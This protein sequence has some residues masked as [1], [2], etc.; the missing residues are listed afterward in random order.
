MIS[1]FLYVSHTVL[2][3]LGWLENAFLNNY[4]NDLLCLPLVLGAAIFFQRNIVLRQPAYALSKWQIGV[5][6]IYFSVM[7]E[8]VFPQFMPRYTADFFDVICYGLGGGL[9][10]IFG[11]ANGEKLVIKN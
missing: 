7:F 5:I 3:R 1:G 6:V 11:N 8:W 4:L 10:W 2:H 9:F